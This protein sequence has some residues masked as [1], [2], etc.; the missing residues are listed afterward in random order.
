MIPV[1]HKEG[2]YGRRSSPRFFV[3]P[4]PPLVFPEVP[5]RPGQRRPRSRLGLGGPP[6]RYAEPFTLPPATR[7]AP[8]GGKRGVHAAYIG[9]AARSCTRRGCSTGPRSRL[10]PY[11]NIRTAKWLAHRCKTHNNQPPCWRQ[12]PFPGRAR[13]PAAGRGPYCIKGRFPHEEGEH[14]GLRPA[15][16]RLIF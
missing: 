12:T 6:S 3:P 2:D 14:G 8:G 9:A 7:A 10:D 15:R 1:N 16:A 4:V 11:Q 13:A 5:A